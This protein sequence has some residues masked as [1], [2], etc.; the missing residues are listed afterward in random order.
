MNR[1]FSKAQPEKGE[2]MRSTLTTID[3]KGDSECGVTGALMLI[4]LVFAVVGL[5][6]VL[7]AQ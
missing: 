3:H 2:W 5:A 1:S 4:A 6:R 7:I